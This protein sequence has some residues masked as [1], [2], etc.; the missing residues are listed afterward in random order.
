MKIATIGSGNIGG[1]VGTLWAKAGHQVMFSSRHPEKLAELVSSAGSAACNGSYE[2]AAAFGDVVLLAIPFYGIEETIPRIQSYLYDRIIIDAM[3]F[4]EDRDSLLAAEVGEFDGLSTSLVASRL[5][6]T[7]VVK[8]FNCVR[9]TDLQSEA[10]REEPPVAMPYA[11]QD[12]DA[13][14]KVAAL[15]RDAGFEPF[16]L[17]GLHD[18]RPA[19]PG[20]ILFTRTGTA[21]ELKQLLSQAGQQ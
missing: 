2:Q 20:G 9:Y 6:E 17:G 5:P 3:N 4:F 16:D 8:A 15:I 7:R 14:E 10:H 21:A 19:Q 13:K 12:P 11:G 18:V 1:T